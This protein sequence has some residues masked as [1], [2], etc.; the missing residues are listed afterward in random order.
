MVCL[1]QR[2]GEWVAR[3][4]LCLLLANFPLLSSTGGKRGNLVPIDNDPNIVNP[5]QL[6]AIEKLGGI[7]GKRGNLKEQVVAFEKL[8]GI[9]GKRGNLKEQVVAI[10]KLGGIGT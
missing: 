4:A 5:R 10:E 6:F 1:G 8:G 2:V 7:G 9:G 3:D